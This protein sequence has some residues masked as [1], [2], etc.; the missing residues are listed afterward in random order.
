MSQNP[1][2]KEVREV[3]GQAVAAISH[4]FDQLKAQP[5]VGKMTEKVG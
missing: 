2:M 4:G 1:L 3:G 5:I